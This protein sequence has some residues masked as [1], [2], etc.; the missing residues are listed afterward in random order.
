MWFQL[1]VDFSVRAKKIEHFD[2]KKLSK[3]ISKISH[4]LEIS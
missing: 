2:A 3:N 4:D 1:S